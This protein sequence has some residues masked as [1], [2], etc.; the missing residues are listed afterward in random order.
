VHVLNPEDFNET[1]TYDLSEEK[2]E[3]PM[4][5]KKYSE[6]ISQSNKLTV[7]TQKLNT[8]ENLIKKLEEILDNKLSDQEYAKETVASIAGVITEAIREKSD[9]YVQEKKELDSEK[10][11]LAKAEEDFKASVAELETKLSETQSKLETLEVEKQEREA[12]ARFNSRM[13]EID[14][15][16][17]LDA[18]DRKI[19]ASEVSQLGES[20]E[21]FNGLKEKFA[22]MWKTKTKAFIEEAEA[23]V[24]E[25]INEEVQK[26]IESLNLVEASEDAAEE[27]SVEDVL[28]NAQTEEV[29]VATNNSAEA[30]KQEETLAQKFSSVFTKENVNIQY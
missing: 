1:A 4:D 17:E 11:R 12:T 14:E 16:Y 21:A 20:Q 29:E 8:M 24:Q 9:Q 19:V 13:A 23:K 18:D 27:K 5:E 7:K 25:K 22:V 3:V 26:R 6:N 10:Q 2:E 15:E 30:S 28:E